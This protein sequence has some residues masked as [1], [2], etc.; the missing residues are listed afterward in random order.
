M[1][2]NHNRPIAIIVILAISLTVNGNGCLIGIKLGNNVAVIFDSKFDL[3][4]VHFI[5]SFQICLIFDRF[6]IRI[7]H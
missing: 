6:F 5:V 4:V 7:R 1:K 2:N 3:G